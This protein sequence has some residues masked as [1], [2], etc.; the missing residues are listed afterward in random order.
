MDQFYKK[1]TMNKILLLLISFIPN[2]SI[3]ASSTANIDL[4]SHA[5]GYI[6]LI[7][8]VSAYFFVM[9][10]EFTHLRKSKPVIL[11]AGIIWAIIGWIM[12]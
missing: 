8:F 10:E 1:L 2:L 6:A 7:I 11:A 5:A 9:I 3:A 4:T 12:L